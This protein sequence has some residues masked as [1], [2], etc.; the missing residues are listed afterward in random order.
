MSYAYF[1]YLLGRRPIHPIPR[2]E[3]DDWL[4]KK[5]SLFYEN[6][7]VDNRDTRPLVFVSDYTLEI[8]RDVANAVS[9][10][11]FFQTPRILAV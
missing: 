9:I 8:S 1:D 4:A 3:H 11:D 5:K 6:Q 2:R 7:D 10:F